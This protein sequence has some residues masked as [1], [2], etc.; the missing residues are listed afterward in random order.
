MLSRRRPPVAT[1]VLLVLAGTLFDCGRRAPEAVAQPTPA[2]AS[3]P[4]EELPH[5]GEPRIDSGARRQEGGEMVPLQ[6]S[7]N[8]D[9]LCPFLQAR[10][11]FLP[12]QAAQLKLHHEMV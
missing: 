7:G 8:I 12:R 9:L 3:Q 4:V 11:N 6:L 1:V 10:L 2:K 5:G